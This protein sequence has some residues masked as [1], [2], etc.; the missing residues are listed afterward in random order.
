MAQPNGQVYESVGVLCKV[1]I[2]ARRFVKGA[3]M[4]VA[5]ILLT[6]L[7][8]TVILTTIPFIV[9]I[10]G[11]FLFSIMLDILWWIEDKFF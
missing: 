8:A 7:G 9:I 2:L 10:V 1:Q 6:V 11:T 4:D 5:G 3:E